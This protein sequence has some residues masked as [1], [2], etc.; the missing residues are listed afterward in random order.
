[1]II[2][3][4]ACNTRYEIKVDLPSD[5]RTVRCAKC[6]NIWRAVPLEEEPFE[7]PFEAP[8]APGEEEGTGIDADAARQAAGG[9]EP[10]VEEEEEEAH[11][12]AYLHGYRQAA[13]D[14]QEEEAPA[15]LHGYRQTAQMQE[16]EGF[17]PAE[18][19]DFARSRLAS[20][21][22]NTAE[23]EPAVPEASGGK[24]SWFGSFMRKSQKQAP[25]PQAGFSHPEPEPMPGHMPEPEPEPEP[26][27]EPAAPDPHQFPRPSPGFAAPA[28]DPNARSLDDARAAVRN[29]FASLGEHR[30][31]QPASS[32][33]APVTAYADTEQDGYPFR[34]PQDP[35]GAGMPGWDSEPG[36]AQDFGHGQGTDGSANDGG[37]PA[38]EAGGEGADPEASQGW[39][40]GWQPREETQAPAAGDLDAQLRAALQAHFPSHTAP[41]ESEPAPAPAPQSQFLHDDLAAEDGEAPLPETLTA[42][43]Q[44]PLPPPRDEPRAGGMPMAPREDEGEPPVSEIVFDE[45][46]FRELE[47]SRELALQQ[48]RPSEPRGALALAAAWG[49][50]LCVAAGLTAGLFGFREIAAD[51]LPGLAP[52]YRAMGMPVTVQPVIFEGIH[53]EWSVADFKPVLHIK[54]AVYNRAHRGVNVP[55]LLVSI[56]DDDPALDKEV[57]ASLPVEGGSIEP[58][59]R[60]EFE[61]ELLSPS[62][63]IATVELQLR[64]VR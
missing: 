5:G 25:A 62:T 26:G 18:D 20:A 37:W 57:P 7:D 36:E 51:A 41:V 47:E 52:F 61:I 55:D 10:E 3:C 33:Q 48:P 4:P 32:I 8:Y 39:L 21:M 49:L 31:Y 44:R 12:P 16:D 17:P 64:N 54:G 1:M 19:P 23:Q 63:T 50:F 58:G 14:E 59:D 29:V 6:E 34:R 9:W 42:F 46:L 38:A 35:A 60:A 11:A 56:K 28:V 15:F 22:E 53:Y 43:W 40:Q 45:R 13:G 27:P 2:E 24:V 30:S